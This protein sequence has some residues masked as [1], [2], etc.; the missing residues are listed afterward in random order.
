MHENRRPTVRSTAE[1]ANIDKVT[2]RKILTEDLNMAPKELTEE[3]KTKK[4]RNLPR[5]FGEAR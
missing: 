5:P 4:S 3:N 2:V 1:Q